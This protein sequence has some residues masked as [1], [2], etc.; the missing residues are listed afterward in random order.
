[1]I[2]SQLL[3]V[4]KYLH[5]NTGSLGLEIILGHVNRQF[6]KDL[7]ENTGSLGLEIILGHVNQIRIQKMKDKF[8]FKDNDRT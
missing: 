3:Y 8:K 2:K 1:M 4:N 5:E 6:F 7:G